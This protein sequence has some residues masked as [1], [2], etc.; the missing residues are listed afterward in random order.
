MNMM[1]KLFVLV[2]L[3][4]FMQSS[5]AQDNHFSQSFSAPVTLN[6]ALTGLI[7]G[8]Y[9]VSMI[10]RDQWRNI[11]T[12]RLSSFAGIGE[13]RFGQEKKRNT[14][15]DLYGIGII[16][17]GDRVS[18]FDFNTNQ[19]GLSGAMHKSLD[20]KNRQYLSAGF[21]FGIVQKNIN[22]ENLTFQDQFNGVNDFDLPTRELLPPNNFGYFDMGAGIHYSASISEVLRL[23]VG[24]SYDHLAAPNISFFSANSNAIDTYEENPIDR[25]ITGHLAI[26]SQVTETFAFSPRVI[27][28]NQ[29]PHTKVQLGTNFKFD[30][31]GADPRSLNLGIWAT[32]VQD[33]GNAARLESVIAMIGFE[34][35]GLQIGLSYENAIQ[36]FADEYAGQGAFEISISYI[37]NYENVVNY[38][39]DF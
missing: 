21:K 6:P 34:V 32:G 2:C 11:L 9:R 39:P 36:D 26:E 20:K 31:S 12:D 1:K 25:K 38:C 15:S 7:E 22:Y 18:Q 24:G 33:D 23:Y 10:Y 29:G 4:L 13:V 3:G 27:F 30:S 19:L 28:L 5:N 35:K 14:S 37:G 17:G 8:G 16:F